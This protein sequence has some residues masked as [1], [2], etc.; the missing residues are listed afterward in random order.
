MGER[1]R[2]KWLAGALLLALVL[3][4]FGQGVDGPAAEA[5]ARVETDNATLPAAGAAGNAALPAAGARL[6]TVARRGRHH[7]KS[8]AKA[9]LAVSRAQMELAREMVND[10]Y[11]LGKRLELRQRVALMTR[12]LYTMRPEVMAE[13]KKQWAEEL[14]ELAQRAAGGGDG[15]RG[16]SCCGRFPHICQRQANM[17]HQEQCDRD[18]GGEGGGV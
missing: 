5:G 7:A 10:S 3:P 13:E 14:F 15:R 16:R 17:G 4:A 2:A 8:K 18:G 9:A 6:E 12:L 11:A 1:V